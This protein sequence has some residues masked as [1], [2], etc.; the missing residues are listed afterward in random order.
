MI[1]ITQQRGFTLCAGIVVWAMLV[2]IVGVPAVPVFA[3]QQNVDCSEQIVEAEQL[4]TVGRFDEAINMLT[5]CIDGGTLD[6]DEKMRAYRL[7]GL[8]Y[9]A[10]DFLEDARSAVRKLLEMVPNYMPDPVQDPPPFT[11][12]VEEVKEERDEEVDDELR[13]MIP[14]QKESRSTLWMIVGGGALAVGAL[15]AVLAGGG[16]NGDDDDPTPTDLPG[17]PDLP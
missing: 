11:Q 8:S 15:V 12:M 6:E 17:P 5:R 1:S 13:E 14:E 16:G 7:L 4:Y 3:Q 2:S 9:I 10:K